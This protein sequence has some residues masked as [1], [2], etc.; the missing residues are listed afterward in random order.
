MSQL[1]SI[2]VKRHCDHGNSYKGKHLIVMG[3]YSSEAQSIIIMVGHGG[4]LADILLERELR[5]LHFEQATGS[6]LRHWVSLEHI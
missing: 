4:M 1:V 5:I 3:A 2:A 6:G